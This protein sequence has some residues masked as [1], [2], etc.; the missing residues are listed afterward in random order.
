MTQKLSGMSVAVLSVLLTGTAAAAGNEQGTDTQN[1]VSGQNSVPGVINAGGFE[2]KPTLGL[3][4]GTNDNVGLSSGAVP[5]TSSSFTILRPKVAVDMPTN[6]QVYSANYSGAYANY[7]SSSQ[8]NYN[9]QNF[10]LAAKNDWTSR[11]NSL[12]NFDYSDG[13]D[14]RNAIPMPGGLT[15]NISKELWHTTGVKGMAH[16]GADGAQGQFELTAGQL[17][18]RYD[19]N[20]SGIT[21]LYN[22]DATPV[23][24]SFF[25]KVAPATHMILQ[26]GTTNYSYQ[27]A[28]AKIY[29][30]KEQQYMVGVKWDATAKT[31][32]NIRYGSVT[33]S[34]NSGFYPTVSSPAWNAAVTWSPRTYSVVNFTL[35]Q[36]AAEGYTVGSSM[37]SRDSIVNWTHEWSSYI[38]SMLSYDDGLDTFQGVNEFFKRKTYEAKL[39]YAVNRRLNAG[40][41]FQN[42][43]R[44]SNVAGLNYTQSIAMILLDGSL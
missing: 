32:G 17:S 31:T 34:F 2:I 9:D 7:T 19:T 21:Q 14:A 15:G 5:K 1:G 28:A 13:H 10:G 3:S 4:V 36:A 8:D 29:D 22:Y 6:G 25:Y 23:T 38:K 37:I 44:D 11:V 43:K 20:F 18:K 41:D 39:S 24:G 35:S 42:W 26:A 12:L 40:I 16:Y 30:S 33:K 27:N